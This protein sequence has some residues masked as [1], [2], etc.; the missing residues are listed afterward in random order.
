[1]TD[2][3]ALAIILARGG[4]RGLARKNA[5]PVGGRPCVTWT[6]AAAC[7]S[8]TVETVVLSSDDDEILRIGALDGA[9]PHHRSPGLSTDNATVDDA[10]RDAAD[11]HA[12]DPIV[13]LYGNVPV[14]PEGL[15]DRAVRTLI[16]T[17]ADSVQSYCQVGKNHPWWTVRVNENA[18]VD[19]WE[20]DV[21]NHNVF[22]RQDL[23]PAFIPDG[24]VIAVT[25]RALFG[26]IDGV[27]DGPHAFFGLD[28]RGV[29]TQAGDVVD[30]DTKIDRI[31]ADAILR[32][33]M[34]LT[35]AGDATDVDAA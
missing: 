10:A 12:G 30:I 11:K 21:L 9:R 34:E 18:S 27:P 29:I 33:R 19:P 6:V 32:E 1:M 14:R 2:A 23:P 17:G 28:R 3:K 5:L 35:L 4:S 20:G 8:E 15:I 13:V 25:R 7:A 31:V 26:E 22:R 16:E 24:G